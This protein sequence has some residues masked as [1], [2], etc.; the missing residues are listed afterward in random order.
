MQWEQGRFDEISAKLSAFLLQAGYK[1]NDLTYVPVSGLT[2]ENLVKSSQ[3]N[4]LTQWYHGPSLL[5]AIDSL[6]PPTRLINKPFRMSVTD[7]FKGGIGS[8]RDVSVGGSIDSGN[9]QIG[10]Q[11]MV[12]P[13]NEIGIIKAI[14]VNEESTTW[15]AAGDSTLMS[16]SGLDI[17]NFR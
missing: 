6:Q 4:Q 9:I 8:G 11:V 16:I 17:L 12:V 3:N 13:G 5:K 15:G 10:E 2:G 14:Q 7:F 1:K